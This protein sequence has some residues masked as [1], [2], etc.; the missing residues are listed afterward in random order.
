MGHK[1]AGS[2]FPGKEQLLIPLGKSSMGLADL[3]CRYF[4]RKRT[5]R[6]ML[7]GGGTGKRIGGESWM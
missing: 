6:K 7:P 5:G 3:G 4:N 2:K 1:E